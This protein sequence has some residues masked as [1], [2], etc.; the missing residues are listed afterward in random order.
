MKKQYK[1]KPQDKSLLSKDNQRIEIR[2]K[3]QDLRNL[4]EQM[5]AD[6]SK[7]YY[8][9]L[10]GKRW[11]IGDLCVITVKDVRFPEAESYKQQAGA[12]LRVSGEF[13]RDT[14]LEIE[15]RIDVDTLIDVHTHPFSDKNVWFSHIDSEDEKNFLKYMRDEKLAIGLAS[16]VLSQTD[17]QARLWEANTQGKIISRPA[18]I[19]TQKWSEQIP[20]SN[21]KFNEQHAVEPNAQFN[22]SVL[23]LGLDTMRAITGNQVIT[24]AGVG[25]VGSIIAEHLVHMGF[26][27]IHLIDFDT[28][29]LSN[30]NRIVA[31]T[32]EDAVNQRVKVEAIRE[33]LLKINPDADIIAHNSDVFTKEAEKIMANSDWILVATDNH[34]SR[35][36]I[37]EIAFRYYVPFITAGVNITVENGQIQDMSGEVILIRI[38]DR[39]CLT[40][41]K[42]LRYNDIAAEIHP[43]LNV[44]EGLVRKGYVQGMDVKEPAVKTLNTH[45]AT[46]AVD[47]LV[48]QYTER[49]QDA[50]IRVYEDNVAPLIY[51]D[52]E[53]VACRNLK[54]HV[55]SG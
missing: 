31:V 33:N 17:Y 47:V 13:L 8:A 6:K 18:L 23:A 7:E 14:L 34:A 20:S 28:L 2:F 25:G 37:Q 45:I 36:H 27:H 5:L 42:R 41:L 40:C 26:R 4:R 50:V 1:T 9:C 49:Q 22:R 29:E 15:S 44:R 10:L 46:M 35:H 39:V 55:C 3:N 38:G 52:K 11:D 53:S 43:D 51:E 30:M 12:A 16:I 19:K 48:N 24:V 32:H 21:P 54:C